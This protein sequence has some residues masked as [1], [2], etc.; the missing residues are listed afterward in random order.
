M[1]ATWGGAAAATEV[2]APAEGVVLGL[3]WAHLEL[4]LEVPDD[5]SGAGTLYTGEPGWTPQ[6]S[7][8]SG[9]SLRKDP[10]VRVALRPGIATE[11][12]VE[13]AG[14]E[15]VL[16]EAIATRA[17]EV[18][19]RTGVLRRPSGSVKLILT[20][21]GAAEHELLPL[22][23]IDGVVPDRSDPGAALITSGPPQSTIAIAGKVTFDGVP[24]GKRTLRLVPG[25]KPSE[26]VDDLADALIE[27]DLPWSGE[28]HATVALE[29]GC[30]LRVRVLQQDGTP[31]DAHTRI[32]SAGGTV[33]PA[34]FVARVDGLA[35]ATSTTG[36]NVEEGTEGWNEV[37]PNL[38]PGDYVLDVDVEGQGRREVP[39]RLERGVRNDVTVQL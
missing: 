15:P 37:V 19:R 16:V 36:V 21:T 31:I 24:G 28:H 33:Q 30:R 22:L 2:H 38:P 20:V 14:Y 5:L 9:S 34:L 39:F 7:G 35:R 1:N 8:L 3:D 12:R 29:R 17:G 25:A 32:D 6:G 23:L 10:V 18:V 11:A 27:L 26:R 13:F 4:T